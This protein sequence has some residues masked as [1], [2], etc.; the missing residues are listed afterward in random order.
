MRYLTIVVLT[1]SLAG[2]GDRDNASMDFGGEEIGPDRHAV[3][4][5]DGDIKLGLTDE[6]VYFAL[7]EE[8]LGKAR[9]EMRREAEQDGAG[10]LVGGALE[11]TVGKALGFRARLPVSEIEDIRWEDE[12]MRI[13]FT[14]PD[15]TFGDDLSV[16]DRPVTEAFTEEA[17]R[18]FGAALRQLK[19]DADQLPARTGT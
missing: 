6:Y 1:L 5:E 7:S 9:A 17:V 13:V 16:A 4:G 14:D 11:K 12:R 15:R 10:G 2:C 3:V 19:G 18:E 8:T